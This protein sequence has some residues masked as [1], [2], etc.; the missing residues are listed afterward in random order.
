ML[1][2]GT[3]LAARG[4]IGIPSGQ[5]RAIAFFS[6]SRDA[7]TTHRRR[8]PNEM[9]AGTNPEPAG[10]ALRPVRFPALSGEGASEDDGD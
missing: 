2:D 3:I 4:G 1:P 9:Q 6:A 7:L 8:A 5:L 10:K